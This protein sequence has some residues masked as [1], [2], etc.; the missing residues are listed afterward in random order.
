M[1]VTNKHAFL[2]C[3][4]RTVLESMQP[5]NTS[6][7]V[8]QKVKILQHVHNISVYKIVSRDQ[9]LYVN[10]I[11]FP[12]EQCFQKTSFRS[13]ATQ[14]G[15]LSI[16]LTASHTAGRNTFAPPKEVKNTILLQLI[17][18]FHYLIS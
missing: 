10:Q 16:S 11:M 17:F 14:S 5:N 2:S 7:L 12:L 4:R 15:V 1:Q 8:D 18:L 6:N 9:S 3:T 13:S